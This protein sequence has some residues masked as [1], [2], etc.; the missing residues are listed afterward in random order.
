MLGNMTM[1]SNGLRTCISKEKIGVDNMCIKFAME[2]INEIEKRGSITV[3]TGYVV[4][5][6]Y[7]EWLYKESNREE[8]IMG[9]SDSLYKKRK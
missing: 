2:I 1:I 3:P 8:N 9:E 4:G 7:E 6:P 5:E